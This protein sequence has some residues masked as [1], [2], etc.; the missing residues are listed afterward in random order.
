M[1]KRVA[2]ALAILMLLAGCGQ[3][4]GPAGDEATA[5]AAINSAEAPRGTDEPPANTSAGTIDPAVVAPAGAIPAAFHGRWGMVPADCTSTRGDAKGLLLV[6]GDG[7][8]FYESRAVPR[9][10]ALAGPNEWSADFDYS[11]E[12]QTWSER[13]TMTLTNSGKTLVRL[14]DGP[15]TYQRCGA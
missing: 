11:G 12:G 6:E 5:D 2:C 15:W 14:G 7:L 8:R 13:T 3:P 10:I 4:D 1:T 9:N